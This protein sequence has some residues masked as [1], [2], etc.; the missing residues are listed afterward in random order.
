MVKGAEKKGGA[1]CRRFPNRRRDSTYLNDRLMHCGAD[2][3]HV[4]ALRFGGKDFREKRAVSLK[5]NVQ[6][7]GFSEEQQS[8]LNYRMPKRPNSNHYA[9]K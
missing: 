2:P 3:L 4:E 7:G 1:V 6:N 5:E 9:I 8:E